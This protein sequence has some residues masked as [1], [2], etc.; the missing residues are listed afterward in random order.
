MRRMTAILFSRNQ[1][2]QAMDRLP[3]TAADDELLH[4][5]APW[6]REW[7]SRRDLGDPLW[8][9]ANFT[10]ALE[11]V[12]IPVLLQGGWQ[13]GFLRQTVAAYARL[14]DRGADVAL[15]M[16]PW[17][18]AEGGAKGGQVLL[19]EAIEWLDADL[20]GSGARVAPRRSTCSSTDRAEDGGSFRRGRLRLLSRLSI[21]AP[22]TSSA[23]SR[24]MREALP[25]SPMTRPT[26]PRR[27]AGPTSAWPIP[28][29]R[30]GR[31]TRTWPS[32][33]IC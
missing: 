4:G 1:I 7:I 10:P 22:A 12:K 3:L 29:L 2:R 11:Q 18:H 17:T 30:A 24:P 5:A 26:R 19:P 27:T 9:N 13:D 8:T 23:R 21:R 16:G 25:S 32:D 33:R 15:T 6:Y 31:T 20:A 14:A 28:S